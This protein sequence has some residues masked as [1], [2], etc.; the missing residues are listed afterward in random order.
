MVEKSKN[1]G[2]GGGM[3]QTADATEITNTVPNSAWSGLAGGA[4]N[5]G[6][7]TWTPLDASMGIRPAENFEDLDAMEIE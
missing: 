5:G 3:N 1:G 7:G 2:L 6:W 4:V